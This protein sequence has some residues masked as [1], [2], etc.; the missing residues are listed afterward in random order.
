MPSTS[1]HSDESIC[2]STE[3]GSLD[4]FDDKTNVELV[5]CTFNFHIK[6]QEMQMELRNTSISVHNPTNSASH[7]SDSEIQSHLRVLGFSAGGS[8]AHA[9]KRVIDHEAA[10]SS[11]KLSEGLSDAVQGARRARANRPTKRIPPT[12]L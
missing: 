2:I 11:D 12:M 3:I 7:P 6:I 8:V 9:V 1:Q 4:V 5:Q 10:T